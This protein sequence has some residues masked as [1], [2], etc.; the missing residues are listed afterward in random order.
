[1]A[2][3]GLDPFFRRFPV[4]SRTVAYALQKGELG[5]ELAAAMERELGPDGWRF[6]TGE[7]DTLRDPGE[8]GVV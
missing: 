5:S 8:R 1:M 7:S 6:V 2:Y 3:G 4:A